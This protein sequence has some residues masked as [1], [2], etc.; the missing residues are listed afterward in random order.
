MTPNADRATISEWSEAFGRGE[1][2]MNMGGLMLGLGFLMVL[3]ATLAAWQRWKRHEFQ[4]PTPIL[5]LQATRAIGLDWRQTR[6]L[7]RIARRCDLPTALTLLV[8]SDTLI[9]HAKAA[10]SGQDLIDARL[11][12]DRLFDTVAR[13]GEAAASLA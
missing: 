5:Y 7:A 10:G 11:L 13:P 4:T 6:L 8:C 2:T 12:A 3:I 9:H 1:A